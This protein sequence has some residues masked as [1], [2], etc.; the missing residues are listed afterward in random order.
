LETL[1]QDLRYSIRILL[2]ARVF[3]AS[4][5]AM[6]TLTIGSTAAVFTLVEVLL[7]RPLAVT[8]PEQLFTIAAPARNIDLNPSYYSHGFYDYLRASN[9]VFR[10]AIASSTAV[11]SGVNLTDGGV[12]ERVLGEL[13]SGNYFD[14]LGVRPAAGRVLAPQDDQTPGAHPV[15]VL[16]YAFWQRRFSGSQDVVGR[17]LS[18][19]GTPFTVVGVARRGFFGTRP[20][21]G[22]D[23]WA[24]L[25]MVQPLTAGAIA[26]QQRNQNYLELMVRLEPDINVRQAQA[27][28]A[29]V[30][31]N[32]LDEGT[33]PKASSDHQPPTLQLTPATTG[34]SLLR[35]QYSQPLLLLMAAVILL[36]LIA[37]ANVA[38]LLITRATARAREMALRT[39]IG[40]NRSRLVRQLMTESLTIGVIGGACGWIMSVYFGR[41]LLSFLPANAEVSQ[42][43]PD[44]RI[45]ALTC[46]VSF[47]SGLLFG[48]APVLQVGR[49][50]P[51]CALKSG[52]GPLRTARRM[53]ESRDVLTVVQV[54]LAFV[55]IMGAGLFARTL[56]NLEAVDMGFR[57]DNV[58][59]A[60]VDPAKSGYTRP[61]T[62]IFFD[63]LIQRL[64]AHKGIDAV[65]L[66]SH[67]S[68][69]GVLP[70]GTRFVSN[71]MHAAGMTAQA[72]GDLTVY[73]NFV[74]AGYFESVGISL[75]RGRPFTESDRPENVQVAILNEAAARL[76]FGTE[77]PIGK[78]IGRGRQGSADIEVVGLVENAKY[79][80]VREAPLPTVYLPFRGGSP[81]TVH[82]KASGDPASVLRVIEQEL[83][84][85]DATLPL[86]QVQTIEARVDDALRQERLLA[87]LSTI[88][89]VVATLI[90]TVGL[91]GLISFSVVQRTREIGIRIA[92]GA[93]P[94]QILSMIL[95]R[96]FVLVGIG[97]LI[98]LALAFSGLRV[99]ATVLYGVSPSDPMTVTGAM[100]L[101]TVVGASAGLVPA[102]NAARTDPCNALRQE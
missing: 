85:L 72:G 10:N 88:M 75:R 94:R 36:L 89:S 77:D 19:N 84:G 24:T 70:A 68:L 86:F 4:V 39:A 81:M 35:G 38:T 30:Y 18:V 65:G 92:V 58:L 53:F 82:V 51:A 50:N 57:R 76:L 78:R 7:L 64:R 49:D 34:H 102:L 40:A 12:T 14:V 28:A 99:S 100:I 45:F 11:S 43:S 59:L 80:S 13:V 87:T 44:L 60:S 33:V 62:A 55:L 26:P 8:S 22:P 29:L 6:L 2:R 15:L 41:I 66:A 83:R 46:L 52:T 42:F 31:T 48:L 74:S 5:L 69:S 101:L 93:E 67:G 32:W 17:T 47:G 9:P 90:A 3:T 79:M 95:R 37:C 1:I 54:A 23:I 16:S 73:N 27:A 20:G 63:Q 56:Q 21:F 71:Q 98:G 96:A 25:M 61:R 91:Y 97:I